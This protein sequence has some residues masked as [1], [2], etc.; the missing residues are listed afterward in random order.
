MPLIF[1][2]TETTGLDANENRIVQCFAK[3]PKLGVSINLEMNSEDGVIDEEALKINGLKR[4][5][6]LSRDLSQKQGAI[7]LAQWVFEHTGKRGEVVC[8]NSEFDRAMVIA[9][10]KREN[11]SFRKSFQWQWQCTMQI[12]MF[13]R[14]R[15]VIR[16]KS[17]K[18]K[19]LCAYFGIKLVNAHEA[20]ADVQGTI[21]LY[22]V[23]HEMAE[24]LK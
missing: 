2:D 17:L 5:D 21:E 1:L 15:K 11:L 6:L 24:K 8:H 18:L 4:D 12:A 19:D 7:Q 16:P 22:R 3:I 10:F 9:W 13:L 20:G 23:F 14:S